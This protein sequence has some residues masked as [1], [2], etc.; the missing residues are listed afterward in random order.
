MRIFLAILLFGFSAFLQAQEAS[1]TLAAVSPM[2]NGQCS[3]VNVQVVD[4]KT[5]EPVPYASV[6]VSP[7]CGTISNYDGEFCLQCLP[8]DVLRISS[9]GYKKVSYR[10]SELPATILLKP[11][12]TTL[13]ELTVVGNDNVL[14]RLVYKMQKEAKKYKKAEGHYFLRLMTRYPGTDELAEAFLSAKSCVQLRDIVFHSGNRGILK[15][16]TEHVL[17]KPDL[18]GLGSTNMHIFLR[19]APILMY[20]GMW[21]TAIVPADIVLRR[22]GKLYDVSCSVFYEDDG[23]E[24]R[25]IHVMGKPASSSYV[26]LEGTLYVDYKKCQLLRFDGQMRGLYLRMYDN[27]RRRTTIAPVEY[28]MHVDYRHDHGF[29]EIANMSGT[30]VKDSV[31]L[32]Y[33]MFNLGD[34]EMTFKERVRVGSNMVRA[35]DAAGYDSTLWSTADIVKR[36]K[37]EERVAFGNNDFRVQGKS[38][39]HAQP[40]VQEADAN[41]YLRE[42]VRKLKGNVMP[43]HRGL[44]TKKGEKLKR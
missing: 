29:T 32:R 44:P 36:T 22:E 30:L 37:A 19:L 27:A 35:I 42:A 4:A 1:D 33:L 9:I 28:T 14:Y 13:R 3:M 25:K 11:T 15:E 34:K 10:A 7:S 23:T 12:H 26:I 31:K 17:N 43:L 6:Y 20:Y 8:S 24:I 21:D 18:K 5:G 38:K 2:V 16:Q 40:S 39:Y 41:A